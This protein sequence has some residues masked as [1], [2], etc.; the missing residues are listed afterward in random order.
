MKTIKR[1]GALLIVAVMLLAAFV[2]CGSGKKDDKN[3]DKSGEDISDLIDV[4]KYTIVRPDVASRNILG[5]TSKLKTSIKDSCKAD[6]NVVTDDESE[7]EYEILIGNTNRSVSGDVVSSLSK[8]AKKE[9]FA[10]SINGTKIVIV[11]ISDDDTLIG[12]NHFINEYVDKSKGEKTLALK[13]G[14]TTVLKQ[15]GKLHYV[16]PNY[17]AV[18]IEKTATAATPSSPITSDFFNFSKIVKLEHQ[19]DKSKNGMLFVTSESKGDYPLFRSEDDGK[20]WT[21]LPKIGDEVLNAT[22]GYQPF[23]FELPVNMGDY[24]A[25][26]LLFAANT[27]SPGKTNLILQASTDFGETWESLGIVAQG[28]AYN[29][30]TYDSEGLWEPFIVYEEETGRLYYTYSDETDPKHN[31]KLSYKYTTDLK[32][33]SKV[34]DMC[35]LGDLRPGMVALT[36]MGNGKWALAYEMINNNIIGSHENIHIKFAD[37][38]TSW[39][40]DDKGTPISAGG[41][42]LAGGPSVV[43]V[44]GGGECGTLIVT[45]IFDWGTQ[46]PDIPCAFFVSFDY[47][48]TF[49]VI[50]NP[51]HVKGSRTGY[52]TGFYVDKEGYLYYVNN[53]EY[54]QSVNDKMLMAKIKIY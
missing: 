33:W 4:S 14:D 31:Q 46:Y 29:G 43:W 26:T 36:K 9:A 23:L 10:I 3:D 48:K 21:R 17:D 38:M 2:A 35:A 11:G 45:A 19:S 24:K 32:N 40:V 18:V 54:I 13:K 27:I 37:S 34:G 53:T 25:G 30:T 41:A 16:S 49:T 28:G 7:T 44:P 50:D 6:I 5:V 22:T 1:V 8:T 39:D 42:G 15:T 12:V 52:S 47:G 20:T 51:L